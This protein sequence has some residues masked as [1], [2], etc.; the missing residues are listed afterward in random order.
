MDLVS[1]CPIDKL[2]A[3]LTQTNDNPFKDTIS[4]SNHTDSPPKPKPKPSQKRKRYEPL[5]KEQLNL[6]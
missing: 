3:T 6:H 2:N 1:A 4:K 5:A